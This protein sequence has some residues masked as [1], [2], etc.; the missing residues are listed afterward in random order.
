MHLGSGMSTRRF[1]GLGGV[2]STFVNT[3]QVSQLFLGHRTHFE[4]ELWTPA[5]SSVEAGGCTKPQ[6]AW[7]VPCSSQPPSP[8]GGEDP[9]QGSNPRGVANGRTPVTWLCHV[10]AVSRWELLGAG[11][12]PGSCP[13]GSAPRTHFCAA[14][15]ARARPASGLQPETRPLRPSVPSASVSCGLTASS[16]TSCLREL[17]WK[18]QPCLE[19]SG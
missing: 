10:E 4:P 9:A 6:N 3:G 11:L 19:G 18:P 16:P 2:A 15:G 14:Q 5:H 1:Q 12:A 7:R 17:S 13:E 8:C